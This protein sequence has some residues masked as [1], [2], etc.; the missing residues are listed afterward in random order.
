MEHSES[1]LLLFQGTKSD[2]L[3]LSM[4]LLPEQV[5]S[6]CAIQQRWCYRNP[7]KTIFTEGFRC[8][9]YYSVFI[10][11][12]WQIHHTYKGTA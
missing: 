11:I 9:C 1:D 12:A 6:R 5:F 10:G 8:R 7:L 4:A 2:F 3:N